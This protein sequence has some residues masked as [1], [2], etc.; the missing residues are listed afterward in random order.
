MFHT[1]RGNETR[2][3]S[4]ITCNPIF[5]IEEEFRDKNKIITNRKQINP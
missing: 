2:K 5:S 4:A 1:L 3:I